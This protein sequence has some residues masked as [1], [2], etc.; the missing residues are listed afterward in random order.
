VRAIRHP[1]LVTAL[2]EHM[3]KWSADCPKPPGNQDPHR[4]FSFCVSQLLKDV[5]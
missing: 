2:L 1:H 4:L 3:G 5:P